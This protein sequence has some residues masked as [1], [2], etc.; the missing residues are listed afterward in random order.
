MKNLVIV[1]SAAKAKTIT[2][3]L[4]TTPELKDLGSF[5]VVASLGHVNDLPLKELGVDTQTWIAAYVVSASKEKVV[6]KLKSAVKEADRV[7]L[8]SDEDTEGE[9]IAYHLQ[10]ILKLNRK[11]TKRITFHEITKSALKHA[12]QNPR[13]VDMNRVA[14]QES[15]RILDRVVGYELSPLL[16]RRFAMSKLSAGRV[17]SCALKMVVDRAKQIQEHELT[18]FW[19]MDGNF[20]DGIELHTKG[21]SKESGEMLEFQDE[22]LA[23][24]WMNRLAKKSSS[25]WTVV[26]SQTQRKKNPPP[27]FT[28]SS[29]QQEAYTRLGLSTKRTMQLAQGLYESGMITYMR[30]DSVNISEEAQQAIIAH[31]VSQYG[32]SMA[33]PRVYKTKAKNAQEAHECIRV[34]NPSVTTIEADGEQFTASHRKLYQLIWKR[35]VATQMAPAI[36]T[37]IHYEVSSDSISSIYFKGKSSCLVEEGYLKVYGYD[38]DDCTK[39]VEAWKN[40]LKQKQVEVKPTQ[41]TAKGDVRRPPSMYHEPSLVKALEKEGIGRPSTYSNIVEKL[42]EKGYVVKGSNPQQQ[43]KVATF[44]LHIDAEKQNE[45]KRSEEIIQIGGSDNDRMVPTSL[46]ERVVEYLEPVVPFILDTKFT[47]SLEQDLDLISKGTTSKEKVLTTFYKKFHPL[48]ENA[49]G[50][51]KEQSKLKPRE[52]NDM[53]SKI[54]KTFDKLGA[55]IV[56]TRYGPALYL[57]SEKRFVNIQSFMTW[58]SITVDEITDTDVKNLLSLPWT[59]PNTHQQVAMGKYGL[60]VK[61]GAKNIRLPKNLWDKAFTQ[62]LVAEDVKA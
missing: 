34:T 32:E 49:L 41:F 25:L 22:N 39:S 59:I 7:Y 54:H 18:P 33:Q 16:W 44:D 52:K 15:R 9:A 11:N 2:K 43:V 55:S 17:Q 1:E 8:A 20:A 5:V 38:E 14:A 35:T 51:I 61:D 48:V 4:N 23:L 36:Y 29:L 27:P 26:F 58:K 62:K 3:Y 31:I 45:I 10:T 19:T 13:E 21:Y 28:T 12:I 30:T 40:I 42:F 24:K 53:P 56:D 6:S 46:G 47:S 57:A 50:E 60:Y 37:D